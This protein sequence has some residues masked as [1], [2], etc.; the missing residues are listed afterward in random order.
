MQ[1]HIGRSSGFSVIE[2]FIVVAV[3]GIILAIVV[4][5]VIESKRNFNESNAIRTLRIINAAQDTYQDTVGEGRY[6]SL[7]DLA[8]AGLISDELG[9]GLSN[10]Y[11]FIVS[12]DIG[13]DR[14]PC[15]EAKAMPL[16][17]INGDRSFSTN[18]SGKIFERA[19][20]Q[21]PGDGEWP[22]R[23]PRDGKLVH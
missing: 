2:L 13:P 15:Y 16:K 14:T 20:M 7:E 18:D 6:G 21:P 5:N 8:R 22:S 10:N 3:V 17:P 4:P 1:K 23:L 9:T 11:T 19:G 12:P